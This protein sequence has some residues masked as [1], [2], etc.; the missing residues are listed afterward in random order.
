MACF[1][2]FRFDVKSVRLVALPWSFYEAAD[3]GLLSGAGSRP[4]R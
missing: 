1:T 2:D 4:G 3:F